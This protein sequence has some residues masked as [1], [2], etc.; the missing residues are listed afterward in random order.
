V[1][2]PNAPPFPSFELEILDRCVSLAG[3]GR[4]HREHEAVEPDPDIV[5]LAVEPRVVRLG[6]D[7]VLLVRRLA[8]DVPDRA[9]DQP[10]EQQPQQGGVA[11][12]PCDRRV[13]WI[14]EAELGSAPEPR[15][16]LERESEPIEAGLAERPGVGR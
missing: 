8:V 6:V 10:V 13:D 15:E 9:R 2:G 7:D 14:E 3:S 4:L 11:V 5:L 16:A 1:A 12:G